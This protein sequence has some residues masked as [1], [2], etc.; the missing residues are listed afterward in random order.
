MSVALNPFVW[1]NAIEDGVPRQPF[2]QQ[3]AR[4]LKAGTH[5]ALFGPRGTGKTS[6]VLELRHELAV[7]HGPDA[8]P[9]ELI[10]VDLRRVI[11][12]PAFVGA[13]SD[14]LRAHPARNLRRK[15]KAAISRLEKEIG[16][17]LGV[18]KAGVRSGRQSFN[19]G[20]ILHGQLRALAEVADRLVIV[21]DEFQR[22]NRCPGEPLSII[23]SALLAPDLSRRLSLLV[24][25]SLRERVELMLHTDTEPIWD[26]T[27]DTELP[28]IG[29]SEFAEYLEHRFEATGK[30]ISESAVEMLIE[31]TEAHPKRTQH[32]AWQAWEDAGETPIPPQEVQEAFDRLLSSTPHTTNFGT[33]IE[34]ML[35]GQEADVNN[36]RALF[37]IAAGE[38]PGSRSAPLPYGL[39]GPTAAKRALER[40]RDRGLVTESGAGWKVVDPLFGEWLRRRDPL[41]ILPPA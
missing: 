13:V 36:A 22:L 18:V 25:G 9:W 33:L 41:A 17:N 4:R 27:H 24:T 5:V 28:P 11:S 38:S 10:R 16:V 14:A 6:F 32:L 15:S 3:T 8:P 37:L 39:S 20:E 34:A 31:L 40:L 30:P 12:L 19:E 21:F 23:R 35:D 26:Q 29:P 1:D 7:E 2:T